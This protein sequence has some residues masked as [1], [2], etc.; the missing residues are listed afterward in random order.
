[1]RTVRLYTEFVKLC[2]NNIHRDRENGNNIHR[3][4]VNGKRSACSG[5]GKGL[6]DPS[7]DRLADAENQEFDE[8]LVRYTHDHGWSVATIRNCL[9]CSDNDDESNQLNV[10]VAISESL[11]EPICALND[12][13]FVKDIRVGNEV[14]SLYGD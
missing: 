2:Y 8:R 11:T 5:S 9:E 4:R 10:I 14:F 6:D 13:T 1:M 7:N 12:Q 3:D